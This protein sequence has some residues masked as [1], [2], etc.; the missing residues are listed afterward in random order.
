VLD[1]LTTAEAARSLGFSK[2]HFY[3]LLHRGVVKYPAG[4]FGAYYLWTEADV[5]AAREAC[6]RRP[7]PGR[8]RKA[9]ALGVAH[10]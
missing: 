3:Q 5:E 6:A 2:I 9:T 10:A 7:R 1:I 8:P 4:K